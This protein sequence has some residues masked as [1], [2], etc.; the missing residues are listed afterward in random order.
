MS[1]SSIAGLDSLPS[2]MTYGTLTFLAVRAY[3]NA[4]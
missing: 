2:A 4:R 1:V 3:W